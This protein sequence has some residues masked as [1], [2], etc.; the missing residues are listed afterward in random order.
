MKNNLLKLVLTLGCICQS[1]YALSKTVY[2]GSAAEII[3]LAYGTTTILRF[4]DPVKTISHAEGYVIK[5]VNEENPDYAVLSVEP[6][7]LSG[8]TDVVFILTTGEMAKLKLSVVPTGSRLKLESIYEVK[9]QKNLIESKAE[10]LPFVGKLELMTAMIRGDQVNGFEI[11]KMAKEVSSG[12]DS[13]KVTIDKVYAGAEFKGYIYT[14]Q[15]RSMKKTFELDI[16]KLEFGHPNQ[17]VLAYSELT[18]LAPLGSSTDKTR[19][20]VVT[21]PTSFYQDA[22]LPVRVVKKSEDDKSGG[23]HD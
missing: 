14:I 3:P 6:R 10:T 21:K 13:A 2:F 11:T 16:R 4:E 15:N 1:S 18:L 8:K 9:S 7:S 22:V 17:A 20:I 5:P 19:L 12:S 23:T